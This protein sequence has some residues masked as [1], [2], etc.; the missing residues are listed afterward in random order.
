MKRALL[1]LFL[2]LVAGGTVGAR[3]AEV[4]SPP[5][6]LRVVGAPAR[7]TFRWPATKNAGPLEIF[8]GDRLVQNLSVPGNSA[9]VELAPGPLYQWR[10]RSLAPG[11]PDVVPLRKLFVETL[12]KFSF[13]GKPGKPGET[14]S[15]TGYGVTVTNG[16]PG[17]PGG[18]GGEGEDVQVTL[19]REGEYIRFTLA[20]FPVN[21][22]FLLLPSSMPIQV[23]SR[24]G[25]GGPGG[26]GEQ[27]A[28][29]QYVNPNVNPTYPYG[30]PPYVDGGAGGPGGPGGNGGRGGDIT[31]DLGGDSSL[32]PYVQA[33][34]PGGAAGRGGAGGRGGQ[35]STYG[36]VGTAVYGRAGA[37]GV[38]GPSGAPGPA[39]TVMIR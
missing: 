16:A 22:T 31:V 13:D 7:I 25:P 4:A 15:S 37:D 20:A 19:R 1:V 26:S 23:V 29:G 38:A 9:Q 32:A 18:E 39:G 28:P 21:R 35:P 30:V 2:V 5:D 8:A 36:Q 34:A 10:V 11:A 27:G 3:A 24:G 6:N 12:P 14:P 33:Q 17:G